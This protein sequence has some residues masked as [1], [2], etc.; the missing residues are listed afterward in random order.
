L[1]LL[2]VMVAYLIGGTVIVELVYALPGLG[3]LMFNAILGRDYT[4]IQGLTLF[5]AVATVVITLVTDLL[6]S[7]IDPRVNT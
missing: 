4:M 5:Y 1:N 6:T 2:G 3:T 7:L